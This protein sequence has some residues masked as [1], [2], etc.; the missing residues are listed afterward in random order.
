MKIFLSSIENRAGLAK[1]MIN[2]GVKFKWNLMSYYYLRKDLA[3]AEMIRDHSEQILIDSGAHSFQKGQK[4][5]WQEYTEQYAEFIKAFDRPN[6]LG[7]FE[8]D[9]DNV[10]GYDK[11]LELRKILERASNKIIPVWHA[12]RG[13]DEFK[14]M[15]QQY[16]GK[17]VAITGFRGFEIK[18]EDYIKFLKYAKQHQ[19]RMHCLGMTRKEVLDKIPFDF[20]D[21]SSWIQNSIYGRIGGRK[22]T[23]STTSN[24]M[25]GVMK[26]NYL[27]WQQKQEYYYRK[28][29]KV[30]KD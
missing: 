1:Q 30:C 9:V 28:H 21:S 19:C 10:L 7:Y 16:S 8:M 3:A 25:S 11:V 18:D 13:I 6:V 4:V 23:R 2:E 17:I 29:R 22:V 12:S 15:C 26:T 5:K 27:L 14:R 24:N 20:V